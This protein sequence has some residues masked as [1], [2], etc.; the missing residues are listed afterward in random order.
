M[1]H[2]YFSLAWRTISRRGLR[3][4]L[5]MLGIFIGIASV[6]ALISIS[7][8]LQDSIS[9]QFKSLGTDLLMIMPG[10]GAGF[11]GFIGSTS[12]YLTTHDVDVIQ[13]ANGVD[14]V[15]GMLYKISKVEY[16]N[17]VK[18]LFVI[19]I[20]T[21]RAKELVDNMGSFN[22]IEGRGLREGDR[23]AI[24]IGYLIAHENVFNTNVKIG[25]RLKINGQGFQVV[26]AL[27]SIGNP[28]DDKQL[29]ITM[30][31]ARDLFNEP[32]KFNMLMVQ[33]KSGNDPAVVAESIKQEMR[34]DRGLK[35]GQ[36]DFSVQTSEQ[37]LDSVDMILGVIQ[38]VVL[39]IAA[40]SLLVGGIGIMNTMYTSVLEQTRNIGIMKAVGA[41]EKDILTIF[42]FESGILG[43]V[44][45]V[46]G[47]TVGIGIGQVVQAIAATANVGFFKV[48][49]SPEL[50]LGALVFSFVVGC[51]SGIAPARQAARLRPVDALRG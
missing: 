37:L 16:G 28:E 9:Q 38:I 2:D 45:G 31:T 7:Q 26:G 43:L 42:L 20:P 47:V 34:R 46:V 32:D 49:A 12:S 14:I 13:R 8:G 36:E 44:G 35:K 15:G 5:T 22:V 21:D 29:Y 1:L 41:T 48:Y 25:D 19:G 10:G 40:I 3:S 4:W 6:V 33:P 51:A 24:D 11:S 39:G 23:Y 50:V 30:D 18:Y 17:E 27:D